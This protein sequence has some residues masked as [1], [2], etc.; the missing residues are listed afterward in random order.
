MVE[1]FPPDRADQPFRMSVLPWRAWRGWPVPNAHGAKPPPESRGLRRYAEHAGRKSCRRQSSIGERRRM[2]HRCGWSRCLHQPKATTNT[3]KNANLKAHHRSRSLI[4][5][6]PRFQSCAPNRAQ[7]AP[8]K[9]PHSRSIGD[10]SCGRLR[11]G[12]KPI[13]RDGSGD[14][15]R[16]VCALFGRDSEVSAVG[17]MIAAVAWRIAVIVNILRKYVLAFFRHDLQKH[18]AA[19]ASVSAESVLCSDCLSS[20]GSEPAFML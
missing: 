13:R 11:T 4:R 18:L 16:G 20:R 15:R 2:F 19:E 9:L 12:P 6:A 10:A 14:R 8:R 3:H 17:K 1:T 7:S 5:Q